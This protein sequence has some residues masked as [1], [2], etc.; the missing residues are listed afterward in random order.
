MTKVGNLIFVGCRVWVHQVGGAEISRG[1]LV[2]GQVLPLTAQTYSGHISRVRDL[3]DHH[4]GLTEITKKTTWTRK[5]GRLRQLCEKVIKCGSRR[6]QAEN[7]NP[8][9]MK[10]QLEG[11]TPARH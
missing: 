10:R 2:V 6:H 9:N 4:L 11:A 3:N 7:R 8:E 5:G 1:S